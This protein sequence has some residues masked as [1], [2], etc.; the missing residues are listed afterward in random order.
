MIKLGLL[1]G[2]WRDDVMS[3]F[4]TSN[5]GVYSHVLPLSSNSDGFI[6][7]MAWVGVMCGCALMVGDFELAAKC[8][9]YLNTLVRVG[10]DA[11]NYSCKSL[12][13]YEVSVATPGFFYKE[14]AQAFAG[15]AGLW[16]ANQNGAK[17]LIEGVPNPML[18]AKLFTCFGSLFGY[19][20]K[21]FPSLQQHVNSM[22]FAYLITGKKP[23]KSMDFLCVGNPFYSAIAGKWCSLDT[24]PESLQRFESESESISDTIVPLQHRKQ[25][26]WIFKS[27]PFSRCISLGQPLPWRY[28]PLALLA[29]SYI[30]AAKFNKQEI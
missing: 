10:K 29:A 22:M 23:P 7:G 6:D 2:K 1:V 26:A 19:A 8:V 21:Y 27:W 28:T 15:P 30:Q 13:G 14:K 4:D 16:F 18:K 20:V 25:S 17:I 3:A 5:G 24:L 12:P 11:R 9:L